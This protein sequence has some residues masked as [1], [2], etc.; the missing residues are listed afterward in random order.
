MFQIKPNFG[1]VDSWLAK[2]G[3]AIAGYGVLAIGNFV[4][5]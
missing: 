1:I 4:T 2:F 5:M 3:Q